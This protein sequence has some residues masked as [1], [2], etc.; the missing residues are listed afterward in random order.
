MKKILLS[1]MSLVAC[2][3]GLQAQNTLTICDG[4][5]TNTS[6]PIN[7]LWWDNAST[8]SQTIF[9]EALLANMEGAQITSMKFYLNATGVQFSGGKCNI[10]LGITDK[11][12]F[13]YAVGITGLTVVATDVTAP[14]LGSTEFEI[15]F[16]E[17]FTYDGGN[18][19][20][21]CQMTEGGVYK[22]SSFLG[23]S[24]TTNTAFSRTTT[25]NFLPK[26]TFT[27]IKEEVPYAAK[28]TPDS[29]GFGKLN[30]GLNAEKK[31][32]L[33]NRGTN[34]FTPAVTLEAPFSTTY[35]ATELAAGESV[36]IPVTFAPT[37][38]AQYNS[39]MTIDCGE[40]G[41]FTVKLTGLGCDEHEI[42]VADGTQSSEYL[43]FYGFWFDSEGTL[44][45]MIYPASMLEGLEGAQITALKFYPTAAVA[46]KTDA[47]AVSVAE[48]DVTYYERESAISTPTNLVTNL[49]T[50][51]EATPIATGATVVEFNF[52]QPYT[53]Q[54]GNLAIQTVVSTKG[55]YGH[56]YFYGTAMEGTTGWCEWRSNNTLESFLPKMTVVYTKAAE[57]PQTVTVTGTVTDAKSGAPIEGVNVTLTVVKAETTTQLLAEGSTATYNA[58]TDAQGEFSMEVVPEQDATYSMTY[59]KEGYVTYTNDDVFIDDP[60]SVSLTADSSTGVT[61]ISV[62]G[63]AVKYVNAM[64]QVSDRPFK[65][66]NIVITENADG[67]RN[68]TKVV[69]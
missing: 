44:S 4:T 41:V 47:L 57:E 30:I 62:A 35:Q 2:T 69:K 46:C 51:V 45:Q 53:Y 26:T 34:A 64:G 23:E 38:V 3:M 54:G 67:T 8:Q 24:Q 13:S 21:E 15:V 17:P 18:L 27:Y 10:S 56:T 6:V 36:E 66:V 5:A 20:F 59:Q 68:V 65:G 9:P 63:N 33:K 1:L 40:A 60:Q 43:P 28:V 25:Y 58:V 19:V 31:V 22:S 32:T 16:D 29:I 42:T 55:S 7:T 49:T 12:A 14:E 11:T 50:V 39:V 37:E 61:S 48:T 52:D